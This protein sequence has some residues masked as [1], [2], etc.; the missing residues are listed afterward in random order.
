MNAAALSRHHN[1]KQFR[2]RYLVINEREELLWP[3]TRDDND[4]DQDKDD[5]RVFLSRLY[6][7]PLIERIL[8]VQETSKERG[9]FIVIS[10]C[11]KRK[12]E[13]KFFLWWTNN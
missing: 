5:D 2:D 6:I 12:Y 13:S 3:S 11:S 4:D 9:I 10:Q 8:F 1:G 7:M